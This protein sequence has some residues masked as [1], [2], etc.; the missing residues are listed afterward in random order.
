MSP[1]KGDWRLGISFIT[2]D[3]ESSFPLQ[4]DSNYFEQSFER[5]VEADATKIPLTVPSI[6]N[7][8]PSRSGSSVQL[9]LP[10]GMGLNGGAAAAAAFSQATWM[11]TGRHGSTAQG[12]LLAGSGAEETCLESLR[13]STVPSSTNNGCG[14]IVNTIS[15]GNTYDHH[16][17]YQ[18]LMPT[19]NY[20]HSM[21]VG[22]FPERDTLER[23]SRSQE[24]NRLAA[25]K[26]RQRKKKEWERLVQSEA[27]LREENTQL[28]Q[29]VARLREQLLAH[30]N[31]ED[32]SRVRE[33]QEGA[34]M[35]RAES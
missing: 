13:N 6:S 25:M 7:R 2:G 9:P 1:K 16:H 30:S 11:A 28:K 34:L 27:L 18:A 21:P 31:E 3:C 35:T 24:R 15:T 4:K 8:V 19:G 23:R 14:T 12:P 32:G 17:A 22:I 33:H 29:E 10:R 20:H 5:A 26:S